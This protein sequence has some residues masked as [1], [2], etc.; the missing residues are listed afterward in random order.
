MIPGARRGNLMA[1]PAARRR[2]L[3]DDTFPGPPAMT[4]SEN[5]A[6]LQPSATMAVSSLAKRLRAELRHA[7]WPAAFP[8][9]IP[10]W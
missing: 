8:A 2:A 3:R 9:R 1:R 5:V 4:F 6:R 7:L 10:T